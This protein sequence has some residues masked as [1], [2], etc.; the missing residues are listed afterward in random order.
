MNNYEAVTK[1][2]EILDANCDGA[3][4]IDGAG[5]N[6]LDTTFGRSLAEQVRN[7]HHLSLAQQVSAV[8]MIQKYRLTQLLSIVAHI[9]SPG[10]YVP[11]THTGVQAIDSSSV[12]V[13][14]Q[15]S[16]LVVEFTD[17]GTRKELTNQLIKV[18]PESSRE[19]DYE[20]NT[21]KVDAVY[22]QEI[23][24]I[25]IVSGEAK[26]VPVEIDW[27]GSYVRVKIQKDWN[28]SFLD[29]LQVIRGIS[30]SYWERRTMNWSVSASDAI[31][32]ARRFPGAVLSQ[33]FCDIL[34]REEKRNAEYESRRI[35]AEEEARVLEQASRY[36]NAVVPFGDVSISI[37]TN[38][39]LVPRE[40]QKVAL[41]FLE[42]KKGK[43]IIADLMGLGKTIEAILYLASHP[44]LRPA[45]IVCPAGVSENWFRELNRFLIP[46]A[47]NTTLQL[48]GRNPF[49]L[50]TDFFQIYIISQSV[51]TNWVDVIIESDPKAVIFDE[52]HGFK[53][54]SAHRSQAA[55]K[56]A[57][58]CECV[59][60]M[61]GT[62]LE[63]KMPELYPL[64]R[65][66]DSEKWGSYAA[67]KRDYMNSYD[68][69][70]SLGQDIRPYMLRRTREMVGSE[71]KNRTRLPVFVPMSAKGRTDYEKIMDEAMDRI[72]ESFRSGRADRISHLAIMESSKQAA[73]AGMMDSIYEWV[74]SFRE[75]YPDKKLVIFALHKNVVKALRDRYSSTSVTVYGEDSSLKQDMAVQKFQ[76]DPGTMILIGS[77][78]AASLGHTMTAAHVSL[79]VEL[80]WRPTVHEQCEG[81]LDRLTQMFDTTHHYLLASGTIMEKIFAKLEIKRELID[82]VL[83]GNS[84]AFTGDHSVFEDVIRDL[85]EERH[86]EVMY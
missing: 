78:N 45:I 28:D 12:N 66:V 63:G 7:G 32:L 5:F 55:Y 43:G 51:L 46:S 76:N 34:D 52:A 21:W 17:K 50:I 37:D 61:S 65:M 18:I 26:S 35:K 13:D 25:G 44:E 77:V 53:N 27:D 59:I 24:N 69:A 41:E 72:E 47:F 23:A 80:D 20:E 6:K 36:F 38:P 30:T 79:T 48:S 56:L 11:E 15:N 33:G 57:D 70:Y 74:D 60:P 85:M 29:Q 22:S 81:R 58:Y 42:L 54:Q 49:P 4:S 68:G 67:Y 62:P 39:E 64:L 19:Y 2:L 84:A 86:I 3:R 14:A 10:N 16:F 82:S 73:V 83:S 8:K 75:T 1:A 31:L 40:Y 71:M 9:P